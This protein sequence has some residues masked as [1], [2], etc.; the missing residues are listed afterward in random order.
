MFM[1][2]NDS[3]HME[4]EEASLMLAQELSLVDPIHNAEIEQWIS[5]CYQDLFVRHSQSYT[6]SDPNLRMASHLLFTTPIGDV[7]RPRLLQVLG[8]SLHQ[9][10]VATDRLS[11]LDMAIN[12]FYQAILL[13]DPDGRDELI[14]RMSNLGI[15]C[16]TR[17]QL[18][19]TLE[20]ISQA[21][22]CYSYLTY[23]CPNNVD[24]LQE[25][26]PALSCF[27]ALRF[28]RTGEQGDIDQA[29]ETQHFGLAYFSS[30]HPQL[31]DCLSNLSH[32]YK[33]RYECFQALSDVQ[34]SIDCGAKA[35]SLSPEGHPDKSGRLCNLGSAYSRRYESQGD[36]GDLELSISIHRQAVSLCDRNDKTLPLCFDC[37][38]N[39]LT[40]K[41][42]CSDEI[43]DID[44][45]VEC[46]TQ[47]VE[48]TPEGHPA[49]RERLNNLGNS[50]GRRFRRLGEV[51]DLERSIR[52][53][54]EAVLLTPEKHIDYPERLENLG[55]SVIYRFDRL[56]NLDDLDRAISCFEEAISLTPR[57]HE[58]RHGR[59]K[60]LGPAV[61]QRFVRLFR[62][63]DL[64][65]AIVCQTEALA[66]TPDGHIDQPGQLINLGAAL[67]YRYD[68]LGHTRDLDEALNLFS[69]AN[70][71]TPDSHAD[72][73][74]Q[75]QSLAS[76]FLSRFFDSKRQLDI[77]QAIIYYDQAL[78]LSP[79]DHPSRCGILSSYGDALRARYELLGNSVDINN[80]IEHHRQALLLV[81]QDHAKNARFYNGLGTVLISRFIGLHQVEDVEE[82][83]ECLTKAAD[84]T[85]EHDS[86]L[87]GRLFDLA[88]GIVFRANAQQKPFELTR[89]TS[90]F[91]RSLALLPEGHSARAGILY[92]MGCLV[93]SQYQ[94]HTADPNDLVRSISLYK[95]AALSTS[96]DGA[97][98]LRAA[99]RWARATALRDG[100]P[101]LE[102]YGR[103]MSLVSRV[104][105]L[106]TTVFERYE[107]V[108][109][110][111]HIVMEAVGAAIS[112]GKH[113]L[114]LE[115]LEEGRC[116]VWNQIA[117]LR[118]PA[119]GLHQINPALAIE[120][121]QVARRLDRA[122][123]VKIERIHAGLR[124]EQSL[125]EAAQMHRRLA[126]QWDELLARVR[127]MPE[128]QSFLL[129][130]QVTTLMRAAQA[131]T[132]VVISVHQSHCDALVLPQ[133]SGQLTHVPLTN[134]SYE[135]AALAQKQLVGALRD[136]DVRQRG[137]R[138]H[139]AKP[140]NNFESVLAL[141]WSDIVQPVLDRIGYMGHNTTGELP[142]V[143]WCATGPL[144]FLPLHAAGLYDIP[145]SR[146][147]DF[148]VSSYTPTISSLVAN[149][150]HCK[151]FCGVLA[152]GQTNT[153]GYQPLEGTIAELDQITKHAF[154]VP[155]SRLDGEKATI[156]A[157]LDA[158]E[159]YSWIHLACHATQERADPTSSAFHLH[160]GPLDLATIIRKPLPHASLAFLSACQ[161][162]AGDE[163]LSEE[164]VHLA[165][166]MIMAGYPS[167]MGTMWSIQD[168]DAPVIADR[169][170]A[171]LLKGGVPN[172]GRAAIALHKATE[173]LRKQVGEKAFASWVPYIHL[174]V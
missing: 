49:R 98:L 95:S 59:L 114:A 103:V 30:D 34:A 63:E 146:A 118:T 150:D 125:E 78:V 116:I 96:G 135:K 86:N 97:R 73:A 35:V 74:G 145:R 142:H 37:L 128:F 110:V 109:A 24:G 149:I 169:V 55:T 44:E 9:R 174:G 6:H 80:A 100:S 18:Q 162:A 47:A 41:F 94:D 108:P 91:E 82:G 40:R 54:E 76:A 3:R 151:D 28:E 29:I 139:R 172:S 101:S 71:S 163:N 19:G 138:A 104:V 4:I 46:H 167:V 140:N 66:L 25:Y 148:V 90:C 22:T 173:E 85:P 156:S 81:P 168:K 115:W 2:E 136:H 84:L 122:S 155:F 105:W 65:R 39:S 89:A 53:L 160:D 32:W 92:T 64:D 137:V 52:Y 147:S 57:N 70:Q 133:G 43:A 124:H 56:G 72:K 12:C 152:V 132:I 120:L 69:K 16:Y 68:L 38:G 102:A 51:V 134:F 161:T 143:T 50:Y 23:H 15:L 88:R 42:E 127:M 77:D 13:T 61:L 36:P 31:A 75:L 11:S 153:P 33:R 26:L 58:Q 119:H 113:G 130:K 123:T 10:F 48:L 21:I 121:E 93:E 158:M 17:F 67:Q 144:A 164:S 165:A 8:S 159:R 112:H 166:G 20:D 83:V 106:G 117:L 107:K 14:D 129:P 99:Q 60:N 154:A 126:E 7:N 141:L 157:V 170:Y 5:D 27:F 131:R 111:S 79:T 45:V 1:L 171:E 62:L 87:P